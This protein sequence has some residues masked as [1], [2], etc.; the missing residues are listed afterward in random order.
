MVS[1]SRG[2]RSCIGIKYV[3]LHVHN[4]RNSHLPCTR[5]FQLTP[6]SLAYATLHLTVAHLFRRFEITTTG[7]TTEED[8]EWNDRFVPVPN[9]RIKGLVKI[10]AD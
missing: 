3:V 7:Y 6:S 10:R 2:S 5:K 8:M 9:G 4:Q 1:F